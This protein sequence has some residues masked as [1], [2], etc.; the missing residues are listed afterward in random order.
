MILWGHTHAAM[1]AE[2]V[3]R[4]TTTDA[5]PLLQD[6]ND[7]K[8]LVIYQK[9]GDRSLYVLVNEGGKRGRC[10][11]NCCWMADDLALKLLWVHTVTLTASEKPSYPAMVD[12]E[13]AIR[14]IKNRDRQMERAQKK[15]AADA[16]K[17]K[18]KKDK[19]RKKNL[20]KKMR[21]REQIE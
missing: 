4:I 2:R 6:D 12:H 11:T 18:R 20:L 16:A 15:A 19:D 10:Q 14:D 7:G 21:M 8:E 1:A 3:P 9:G 17:E 5:W 13:K